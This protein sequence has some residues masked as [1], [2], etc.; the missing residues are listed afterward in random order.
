MMDEKKGYISC[1]ACKSSGKIKGLGSIDINCKSCNGIG[2]IDKIN[3]QDE[4]SLLG[5]SSSSSEPYEDRLITEPNPDKET[6]ENTEKTEV[7]VK[8]KYNKKKKYGDK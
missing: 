6:N 1:S 5:Y 4:D 2:W 8:R 7:K 3:E